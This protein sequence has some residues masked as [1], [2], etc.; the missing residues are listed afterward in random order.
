[1]GRRSDDDDEFDGVDLPPLLPNID[2]CQKFATAL[3]SATASGRIPA[4]L[5]RELA[6]ILSKQITAIGVQEGLGEMSEL[7]SMIAHSQYLHDKRKEAEVAAR[8]AQ[9]ESQKFVT[10]PVA[11]T[12]KNADREDQKPKP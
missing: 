10:Y 7:R 11:V 6:N 4:A 12:K 8:Y 9:G 1:M 3:A 5:A 2:S